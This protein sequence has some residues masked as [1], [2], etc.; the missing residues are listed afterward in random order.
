MMTDSSFKTYLACD[1]GAE[2]SRV[3]A[4]R[5][6]SD[7]LE[8]A[9]VH[10][11][12]SLNATLGQTHYWDILYLYRELC[13]GL[14]QGRLQYG[15]SI[16]SVG[17]D[18]W[19]VDYG[20]LDE[21]GHLLELPI[22]YRDARTQGMMAEVLELIPAQTLYETTGI[23]V[24]QLNT[25]FQLYALRKQRPWLLQQASTLLMIPD[26]LNYFFTG[27]IC[28]EYTNATTTQLCNLGHKQWDDAVLET[29]AIPRRILP[30]IVAPGSLVGMPHAEASLHMGLSGIPVIAPCTHDTNSAVA[31]LPAVD[32][33]WAYISCGTWSVLGTELRAPIVSPA[34]RAANFT[35]E[36]GFEG[37]ICFHKNIMGLWLLQQC[38]RQWNAGQARLS[39]ETVLD[40]VQQ[41]KS[42][43]SII[44]IDA[45]AF[46]NSDD[47]LRAV[48]SE[49]QRTR[50]PVPDTIG[51][52]ATLI[53]ESLVL[54]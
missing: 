19:G 44:D 1:L 9:E 23:Q 6:V 51:E 33:D 50:Q 37:R 46:F 45:A 24:L 21:A 52:I 31:A 48:I 25:L 4:G 54:R 36:G 15:A 16:A 42:I 35:N 22:H 34:A 7:R 14:S 17:I 28:C 8:F 41:T 18:A 27:A 3:I 40:A 12:P 30:R 10:R 26:L 13:Q 47:M 11:F 2:S 32:D 43:G 39:Y 49:C 5:L 20:L 29:L 38:L 53:L